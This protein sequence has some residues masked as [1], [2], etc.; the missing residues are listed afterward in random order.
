MKRIVLALLVAAVVGGS[1]VVAGSRPAGACSCVAYDDARALAAAD[2]AFVG[3]VAS[4]DRPQ[5]LSSSL[6]P[7]TWKFDVE[8]VFKGDVAAHQEIVS[9][10]SSASC[11]IELDVGARYLVFGRLGDASSV[12]K[13]Q[14]GQLAANLCG[15]TRPAER[16]E[17]PAGFPA[18]RPLGSPTSTHRMVPSD[19]TVRPGQVVTVSVQGPGVDQWSGGVDSYFERRHNGTWQRRYLLVWSPG[20]KPSVIDLNRE[21]SVPHAIVALGIQGSR[22]EVRIPPVEPGTYRITRS[23]NTALGP[24]PVE[25][26]STRVTVH[27]R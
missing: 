9:A 27:A 7:V 11:G 5:Q 25:T 15:G 24:A 12:P 3:T 6:D 26:L 1:V 22:F 17:N 20:G 10:S 2:A 16:G 4:V 19:R 21:S 8:G 13:G 18:A 14:P 23:F